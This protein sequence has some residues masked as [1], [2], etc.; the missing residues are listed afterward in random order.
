MFLLRYVLPGAL[1]AHSIFGIDVEGWGLP[2]HLPAGE[3][4][5]TSVR[6]ADM[7]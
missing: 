4:E 2:D 7:S 5:L 3:V 1:H 6:K